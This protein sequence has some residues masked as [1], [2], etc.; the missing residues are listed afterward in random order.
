MPHAQTWEQEAVTMLA[1][2]RKG[3]IAEIS[4]ILG[5]GRLARKKVTEIASRLSPIETWLAA[6]GEAFA[7]LESHYRR[8]S[9]EKVSPS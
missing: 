3:A 4:V 2:T 5:G 7:I 9:A 8:L 1:N 6:T